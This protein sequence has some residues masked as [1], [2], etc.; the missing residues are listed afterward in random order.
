[1]AKRILFI[2]IVACC[3]FKINHAQVLEPPD[4]ISFQSGKLT[5]KALLWRPVGEGPF[6]TIIFTLGSYS[7]SD[8]AHSPVKEASVLGSL[9]ARRGY[10]FFALF[11]RGVGL[12]MDQGLNSADMI[13]KAFK[14]NG[15]EGRNEAQLQ[16]LETDQLQD[17]ISGI[18]Y[19]RKR[20]DVD[21][22][23][24]AIIGHS[25]GGSLALLV[26]EHEPFLKAVVVFSG[27]G[28]SWNLSP[29]LRIR[30]ID[31]VKNIKAPILFIHAQNDYSTTPGYELDSILNG[32]NKPHELKIY[33]KFGNTAD[34]GHNMIFRSTNTWEE[35]VF[36]FL[37]DNLRS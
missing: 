20:T 26:A 28:Y 15:Q 29:R 34:E 14:Q 31:A 1:M 6:A 27:A 18:V 13:E 9:F 32:L 24:M 16:Q 25:F 19:L 12:S 5:L 37:K 8:T 17:M 4:T 10:I 22:Q 2:L 7:K 23:R 21:L 11:R 36:K 30:L 3:S 33:S 35:D